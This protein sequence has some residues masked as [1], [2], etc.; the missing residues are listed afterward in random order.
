MS[1]KAAAAVDY[2]FLISVKMAD[3]MLKANVSNA[4]LK[5]L[6]EMYGVKDESAIF[7]F[8]F[9]THFR[10]GKSTGFWLDL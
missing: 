6:A 3:T 4:D 9:R 8:K 5:N 2:Q 7:V 1:N 10:G